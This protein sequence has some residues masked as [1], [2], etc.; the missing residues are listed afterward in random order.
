MEFKCAIQ[1][2]VV[3]FPRRN[4]DYSSEACTMFLLLSYI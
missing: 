1:K 3:L 2:D 4:R